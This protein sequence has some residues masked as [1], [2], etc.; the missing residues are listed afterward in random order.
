[1][2]A[3]SNYLENAILNHFL[4]NNSTSS[5]A[6]VFLALHASGGSSP[7][8]PG[9]D[10]TTAF[11]TECAGANA[12]GWTSYERKVVTFS[13]PS[14]GVTTNS[15]TVTFDA[16]DA[17]EG[18]VTITGLSIWT[19][20]RAGTNVGASGNMLFQGAVDAAKTLSANDVASFP[21]AALTVT[22][23]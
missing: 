19:D 13:S 12:N 1:M 21:S 22:V 2:S 3:F 4:R 20:Q 6:T 10:G 11:D 14:N 16:V 8:A 9:D 18:P 5:P 23:D 15:A 7:T 17:G